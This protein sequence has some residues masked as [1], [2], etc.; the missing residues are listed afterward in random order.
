MD[1]IMLPRL[2]NFVTLSAA[3][4]Y[5]VLPSNSEPVASIPAPAE[6]NRPLLLLLEDGGGGGG[7]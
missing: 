6:N 4:K 1:N 7:G 2:A 3:S 5:L